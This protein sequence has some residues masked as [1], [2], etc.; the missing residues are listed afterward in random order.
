AIQENMPVCPDTSDDIYELVKELNKLI[1]QN[2]FKNAEI[3]LNILINSLSILGIEFKDKHDSQIV[4]LIKEYK[5]FVEQK[6]YLKSDEIRKILID[7]G[8]W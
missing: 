2:D 8:L 5:K 3:K 7:K 1:N 4:S 6:E